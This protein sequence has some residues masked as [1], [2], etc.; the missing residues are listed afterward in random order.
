MTMLIEGATAAGYHIGRC[1]R[2]WF[3]IATVWGWPRQPPD[4]LKDV[5]VVPC[6]HLLLP[7][8]LPWCDRD[9]Q[10]TPS[11]ILLGSDSMAESR[12]KNTIYDE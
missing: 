10:R 11:G 6:M 12:L 4:W 5:H 7:K 9:V 8:A 3:V 2:Q 1:D